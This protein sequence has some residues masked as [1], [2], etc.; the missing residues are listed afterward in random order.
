MAEVSTQ[1]KANLE[2][3]ESQTVDDRE[4][5]AGTEPTER[6]EQ[7]DTEGDELQDIV[8]DPMSDRPNSSSMN[9]KRMTKKAKLKNL[10]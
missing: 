7:N 3:R 8:M 9:T 4:K 2:S 1:T 10:I 6:N 5:E